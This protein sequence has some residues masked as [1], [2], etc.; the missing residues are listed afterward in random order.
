M[1]TKRD[2]PFPS[3]KQNGYLLSK[4]YYA[5]CTLYMIFIDPTRP[6][7]STSTDGS[8]ESENTNSVSICYT[9]AVVEWKSP[10]KIKNGHIIKFI[11]GRN[12][13]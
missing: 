9:R 4:I 6:Q 1:R 10:N 11:G 7:P 8:C 5:A 12:K 2:I 3:R 13:F